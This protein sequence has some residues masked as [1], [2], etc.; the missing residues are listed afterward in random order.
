MC[1]SRNRMQPPKAMSDMEILIGGNTIVPTTLPE[2]LTPVI[3]NILTGK[4]HATSYPVLAITDICT[5]Q[6]LARSMTRI[7]LDDGEKSIQ[8]LLHPEVDSM[9]AQ[10][11]DG[12]TG[13][14]RLMGNL[15]QL[16]KYQ[17]EV[18]DDKNNGEKVVFL[19]VREIEVLPNPALK[20][21]WIPDKEDGI[22]FPSTQ[23]D[24]EA[25]SA[26]KRDGE[27]IPSPRDRHTP[28]P[29]PQKLSVAGHFRRPNTSPTHPPQKGLGATLRSLHRRDESPSK[30]P[31]QHQFQQGPNYLPSPSKLPPPSPSS[32]TQIKPVKSQIG[33]PRKT[34]GVEIDSEISKNTKTL[35]LQASRP[36]AR[37]QQT[38][39]RKNGPQVPTP[40]TNPL[41]QAAPAQGRQQRPPLSP[42]H[43]PNTAP[44]PTSY[45]LIPSSNLKLTPL[46]KIPYLP[47]KQNWALSTLCIISSLSPVES[48]H[49]PPFLQRTA[50]LAHPSTQKRAHLT[51]FLEPE[52]FNPRA[53]EVVLLV[54]VKNHRFDGGSL[55]KYVSDKPP[56]GERWWVGE[57]A[58]GG[59]EWCKDEVRA[60]RSWW[61]GE[62]EKEKD[63]KRG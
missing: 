35:H 8:A 46:S 18:R 4:Q 11:D 48:S 27:A 19:F 14:E 30:E 31:T 33:S 32:R 7:V 43:L 57:D 38:Q 29:S 52:D 60:L 63:K 42:N 5:I 15:I 50:R 23:Q 34:E 26:P 17:V 16:K 54:G 55:K 53:G 37:Q 45:P 59:W 36:P 39:H 2:T 56:R 41:P 3:S 13:D 44:K 40:K 10:D 1:F 9:L 22:A 61:E 62:M 25:I 20:L 58:I 28:I 12:D 6:T 51:V 47:Y 21:P 24:L 49:L